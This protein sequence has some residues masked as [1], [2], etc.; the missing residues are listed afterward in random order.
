MVAYVGSYY[1]AEFQGFPGGGIG[2]PTVPHHFKCGGSC[3]GA[4]L[5]LVCG[6]VNG[7]HEQLWEG[8]CDTALSF[9]TGIMYWSYRQTQNGYK[10]C[11]VP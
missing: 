2:R 1:L 8:S 6:R 7:R 5:D 3:S 11:S 4:T 9:F 10:G